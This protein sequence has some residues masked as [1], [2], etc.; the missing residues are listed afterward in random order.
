MSA[1]PR[2]LSQ[3]AAHEAFRRLGGRAA[4]MAFVHGAA[5]GVSTDIEGLELQDSGSSDCGDTDEADGKWV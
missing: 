4:R 1:A 2:N 3:H 5:D